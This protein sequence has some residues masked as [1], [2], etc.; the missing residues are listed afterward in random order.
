MSFAA[1]F[2]FPPAIVVSAPGRVNVIGD[3]TD[4]AGL[5]VLPFAIDRRTTVMAAAARDTRVV[6]RRYRPAF[7]DRASQA[8]WHRYVK[9]VLDVLGH[10]GGVAALV[11]GDLPAGG[12]LSS[13]SALT[14]ALVAAILALA[15]ER[16]DPAT[17]ARV[18]VRAEREAGV[19]SGEMDQTVIAHARP[20]HALRIEFPPRG[21]VWRQ[22]PLGPGAAF[23]VA[24]SGERAEK[25]A[26]A[27]MAYNS[28]VVGGRIATVLLAGWL[29]VPMPDR[30]VLGAVAALPG[31]GGLTA[32]LPDSMTAAA[33]S[34]AAGV[35]E[36]DLVRLA[37]GRFP[38]GQPVP[39]RRVAV[40]VLAEA[41]RVD[42]AEEALEAG[43]VE[44]LGH[45]LDAS[46]ASLVAFGASTPALDRLT[47]ALRRAG[48]LGARVTGAGFG[49]NALALCRPEDVGV[50]IDVGRR[51]GGLDTF[52]VRPGAGLRYED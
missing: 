31:A 10:P 5:P 33:A 47:R 48:A 22:V 30:L 13:S 52:E 45:L 37:R 38:S 16:P 1:R 44:A 11:D 50:V 25:G 49:G 39:V 6:S 27:R 14:M 34:R 7:T 9:A 3:H 35:P 43:D 19:E 23:V 32:R 18:A 21:P 41:R 40:H 2:G 15:G 12:G 42:R 29:D 17:V 36:A 28:R 26:G 24:D 8:G 20:G 46:H 4:Y 51:T